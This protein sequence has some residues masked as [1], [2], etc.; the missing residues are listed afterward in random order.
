MVDQGGER[1]RNRS[2]CARAS[3]PIARPGQDGILAVAERTSTLNHRPANE[4][5]RSAAIAGRSGVGAQGSLLTP[6]NGPRRTD[7]TSAQVAVSGRSGSSR[8]LAPSARGGER[9]RLFSRGTAEER[10]EPSATRF[11]TE[12]DGTG[13]DQNR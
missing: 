1:E 7:E 5:P 10:L 3:L 4:P 12:P 13:R 11:A 9:S 8:T 6:A 2:D